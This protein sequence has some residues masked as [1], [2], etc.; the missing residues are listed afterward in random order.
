M[1]SYVLHLIRQLPKSIL[2]SESFQYTQRG[3][4]NWASMPGKVMSKHS[5]HTALTK[6]T[7]MMSS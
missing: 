3:H 4:N 1:K 6:V 2:Q 5:G 7:G